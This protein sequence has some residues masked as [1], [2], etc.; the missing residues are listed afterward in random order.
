MF[1]IVDLY[2][3]FKPL[4]N[5]DKITSYPVIFGGTQAVLDTINGG[6]I[7]TKISSNDIGSPVTS[8][9]KNA[10][11]SISSVQKTLTNNLIQIDF[12]KAY[13]EQDGGFIVQK[14]I[15]NIMQY[16]KSFEALE[17]LK[18]L[19]YEILPNYSSIQFLSEY[20]EQKSLVNRGFFDF[21]II[22]TS[23]LI[24]DTIQLEKIKFNK[25]LIV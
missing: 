15:N 14:E 7:V 23:N 11:G 18:S 20:T 9:I 8:T 2:N 10:D 5:E 12:Y 24:F 21:S 4:D 1:N 19:D 25:G 17:Y 3:L 22:S 13:N 16:L 6:F